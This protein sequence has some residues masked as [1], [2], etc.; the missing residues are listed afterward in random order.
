V[1][2]DAM[3]SDVAKILGTS[4]ERMQDSGCNDKETNLYAVM[5]SD[6]A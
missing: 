4:W 6:M 2:E 3:G 5:P 1:G